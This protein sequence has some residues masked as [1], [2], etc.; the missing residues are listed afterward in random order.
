MWPLTSPFASEGHWVRV[1]SARILSPGPQSVSRPGTR[2]SLRSEGT[3]P[4]PRS[5]LS[6]KWPLAM[7]PFN[8]NKLKNRLLSSTIHISRAC[9]Y[10][11]GQCQTVP[12][13]QKFL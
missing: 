1:I 13:S 2:V 12:L 11:F 10:H 4:C 8:Y 3:H 9:G 6:G 5:V 7:W